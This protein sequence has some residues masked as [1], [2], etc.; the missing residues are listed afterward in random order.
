[1]G[2]IVEHTDS[3]K[4]AVAWCKRKGPG[5]GVLGQLGTGGTAPVFELSSPNGSRALKIYDADFSS[6]RKG[7][8]ELKRIE[9]QLALCGHN[10]PYLVQVYE[11]ATFEGRLYLLMSRAP[12]RELEQRLSDV[13]PDKIRGIVDQVARAAIF[14]RGKNLCHR[15][16]K[17][18]NIF[19]T[20][21]FENATLLDISVIR[22]INDPVGSGTDQDGQLP[23][24]ATARYS[25]PEYL[26]RLVDTGPELWHALTVYQL[27]ALLHDLIMRECPFEAEYTRS[28]ENRYRFAW[29]I[30][31]VLPRV[32]A[33]NVDQ[34]LVFT[35]QRALD[36]D[37]QRRS[38]LRLE[39]FLADMIVQ[40]KHALQSLGLDNGH[41]TVQNSEDVASKLQRL[42]QIS[43]GLEVRVLEL[44]RTKGVIGK[45]ELK[46][47][48]SDSSRLLIFSWEVPGVQGEPGLRPIELRLD[49]HVVARLDGYRFRLSARVETVVGGVR[50]ESAIELP[51]L[52]DEQDIESTLLTQVEA[53]IGDLAIDITRS[54]VTAQEV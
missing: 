8:V 26:F 18:A 1:M 3:F 30:A 35:A 53:A 16:I 45:H 34:D 14:L 52:Q 38:V 44:L 27:G 33:D 32:Q 49:I 6:G 25:P 23:M 10:C 47:G 50:R 4:I 19:V 51:E 40:R 20:D 11:G 12:G 13:P 43:G 24:L 42:R 28:K 17:A 54:K 31:T 29:I 22:N 36:K 37:W 48:A 46:P 7:G 21:D 41:G 2:K 39:D 15:D 9:Q 5:W